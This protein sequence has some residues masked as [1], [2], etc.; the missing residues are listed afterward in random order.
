MKTEFFIWTAIFALLCGCVSEGTD[1]AKSPSVFWKAPKS[2]VP[3]EEI[4]P[5][6]IATDKIL[7]KE[8]LQNKEKDPSDIRTSYERMESGKP[9]NLTDLMDIALENNTQTRTY[10]FQ[11]KIYAA[12]VGVARSAYYPQVSVGA[13][14][15]RSKVKFGSIPIPSVGSY[16]ETG[17]GPSAQ[18][19]WLLFDFGKREADILS[20]KEALRA[21]NFD[22]NQIIQDVVLNVNVAYYEFY[23][24]KGSVRAA[25]LSLQDALTAYDSANARFKEGV[26]NKQDM[27][28]ALA[29]A[30]NAEYSLESAKGAVETARANLA[31]VLGVSVVKLKNISED[32]EIPSSPDTSKKI[33]ELVAQ[34]LRSRQTLLA[35]YANLRKAEADTRSAERSFLPQLNATGSAQYIDYSTKGRSADENYTAGLSVSWSIFEGFAKTYNLISARAAERAQ[36]Q[37]LKAAEIEIISEIWSNYH[38]YKSAEKQV[39]STKAAV[40]ASKEAFDAMKVGYENGV[41]SLTDFL[42]AQSQLATARER[43]VSAR[44]LLA[45]SIAKLSHATGSLMANT[46]EEGELSSVGEGDA[47]VSTFKLF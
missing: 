12:N 42:N 7:T 38:S 33:D 25:E 24:A 23:S 4:S 28:N 14:I 39:E 19:N 6:Q 26:G 44:A 47:S 29:N 34:A 35:A 1:V 36:A 16:Y 21:A 10:W 5:E 13:Q 27:L 2:A 46:R 22:Y 43:E 30:R 45:T 11:S 40:E 17:Y 18:I 37:A 15:Y 3:N 8:E 41:N 20:A 31:S 9:L 32:M